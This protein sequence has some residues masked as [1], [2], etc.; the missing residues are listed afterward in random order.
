MD[1]VF[2]N[3]FSTMAVSNIKQKYMILDKSML[4]SDEQETLRQLSSF[5]KKSRLI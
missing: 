1:H 2:K 4:P 3:T 5:K